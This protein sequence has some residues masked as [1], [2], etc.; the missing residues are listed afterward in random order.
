MLKFTL[1]LTHRLRYLHSSFQSRLKYFYQF[2]CLFWN[3]SY[4]WILTAGF[5]Q[6]SRYRAVSCHTYLDEFH[7][8]SATLTLMPVWTKQKP[9]FPLHGWKSL[10]SE[11]Q[12]HRM[13]G[14]GRDLCGSSSPSPLPKQGH[15]ITEEHVLGKIIE[16]LNVT[17]ISMIG[18]W[19][20]RIYHK[21]SLV[22]PS[23]AVCEQQ[24][25]MFP[26]SV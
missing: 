8:Y 10:T 25:F 6:V 5:T 1:A 16:S 7:I 23:N 18:R 12:N 26:G 14:V 11:G 17:W 24:R 20:Q 9:S 19:V 22:P 3:L 15:R 4:K 21:V 2:L 13:L